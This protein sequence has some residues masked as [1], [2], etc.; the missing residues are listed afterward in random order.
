M[1]RFHGPQAGDKQDRGPNR[2]RGPKGALASLRITRR[3]Q[4]EGRNEAYQAA[5]AAKAA[6]KKDGDGSTPEGA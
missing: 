3:A 1:S 5:K 2:R 6:G 4:A